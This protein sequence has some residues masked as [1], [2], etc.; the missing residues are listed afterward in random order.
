M[1]SLTKWPPGDNLSFLKCI[2]LRKMGSSVFEPVLGGFVGC[3][4]SLNQEIVRLVTKRVISTASDI[5]FF[6]GCGCD[7]KS[8]ALLLQLLFNLFSYPVLGIKQI[9]RKQSFLSWSKMHSLQFTLPVRK[10]QSK[11][12][13]LQNRINRVL[14]SLGFPCPCTAGDLHP[15]CVFS[16]QPFKCS[17]FSTHLLL[18]QLPPW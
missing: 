4:H 18:L 6:K 13:P 9:H 1:I 7:Q 8:L 15:E 11:F 3:R 5:A 10:P 12:S 16:W 14:E 2:R 17:L